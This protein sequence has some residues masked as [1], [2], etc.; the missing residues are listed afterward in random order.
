ME[1]MG[2][3][4]GHGWNWWDFPYLCSLRASISNIWNESSGRRHWRSWWGFGCN[5]KR[6]VTRTIPKPTESLCMLVQSLKKVN[7]VSDLADVTNMSYKNLDS[8]HVL[9]SMFTNIESDPSNDLICWS[10]LPCHKVAASIL[11][12]RMGSLSSLPSLGC[13]WYWYSQTLWRNY[14]NP[15][16]IPIMG[17]SPMK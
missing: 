8:Y 1:H 2:L 6:A 10:G 12:L 9:P 3:N 15:L 5:G 14:G 4:L 11:A 7:R 16:I 17:D 13:P